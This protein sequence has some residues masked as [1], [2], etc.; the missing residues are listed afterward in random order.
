MKRIMIA[1]M[2]VLAVATTALAFSDEGHT[3]FSEFLNGLK[4]APTRL[5]TTR[6]RHVQRDDQQGRNGDRL[7]ADLR[8]SRGRR[9]QAHI[10]IG[11]PQNAGGIVLWLCESARAIPVAAGTPPLHGDDPIEPPRRQ[12]HGHADRRRRPRG[13]RTTASPQASGTEV[14]GLIR[15][16]RTYANVHSA[17]FPAGEIRSQI[18]NGDDDSDDHG[19]TTTDRR[20][21]RDAADVPRQLAPR[22]LSVSRLRPSSSLR[23]DPKS[24]HSTRPA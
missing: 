17:K 24:R 10:H 9:P 16:G 11:H 21:A 6:D 14:L 1:A 12:G 19:G 20:S 7:R 2:A 4:E 3:R 22:P 18:D 13:L 5:S 15:A 8:G 23:K